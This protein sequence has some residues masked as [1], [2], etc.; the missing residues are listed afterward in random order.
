MLDAEETRMSRR[1]GLVV[2]VNHYQDN[3]FQPLQFAENDARAF[4]QWLVNDKGGKWAPADVQ[5]VYGTN[6]KRDLVESLALQLCLSVA[7][8][9]DL[10]LIYIASHTFLDEKSGDGYLALADTSYG[11]A[12]TGLHLLSLAQQTVTRSRA[13][14]IVFMLDSFQTGRGWSTRRTSPYDVQPLLAPALLHGIQQQQNRILLCSCRGNEFSPEGGERGLGM[15]MYRMIIGLSGLAADATTGNVT[16]QTLYTYLSNTLGDQQRPQVFGQAPTPI[17]LVGDM[18][19]QQQVVHTL[20]ASH[21]QPVAAYAATAQSSA[22][23]KASSNATA[24]AQLSP[25]E[26]QQQ[27]STS[28]HLR[29]SE[30]EQHSQQQSSLL[31]DQALQQFQMQNVEQALR[32]TEQA[33]HIAPGESSGLTLKGQILGTMCRFPE[34]LAVVEQLRQNEPNNAL[35]WSMGAVLLTNMGRHQEALSAIEHSLELDASNPES[36]AI[37]TNIMSSIAIA[38]NRDKTLPKNELI[39]SEKRRGGPLSFFVGAGLQLVGL[40]LGIVGGLLPI[41]RATLPLWLSFLLESFGLALLCVIAARGS[42]RHGFLR[43]LV[44][45]FFSLIP[46]AILGISLGYHPAY[47]KIFFE[48]QAHTAFLLPLLFLGLWLAVAAVVPVLVAIIGFVSG[49]VTGVRRRR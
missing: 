6:A 49:M 12:S 40:L 30:I 28:G 45:L 29:S 20:P 9:D 21:A 39:A 41:L 18:P 2:G 1:L 42:Y 15:L 10:V 31:L 34:A 14:Q 3:T 22:S 26:Q 11:N 47:R 27:R 24:T 23:P 7:Q 36:Y 48:L 13:A 37:K 46:A 43:V 19:L 5:Y 16:L 44:T 4:A 38:Q 35:A 32:L 17:V 8:P 25:S 33:L